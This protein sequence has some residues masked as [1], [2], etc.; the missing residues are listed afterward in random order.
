MVSEIEE[1]QLLRTHMKKE[2]IL[3]KIKENL[4]H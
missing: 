1:K 4:R 3:L 2:M